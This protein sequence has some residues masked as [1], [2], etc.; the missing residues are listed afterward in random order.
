MQKK[1][2]QYKI[3]H[4]KKLKKGQFMLDTISLIKV[5]TDTNSQIDDVKPVMYE[6]TVMD[7]HH[8]PISGSDI[9]YS[10]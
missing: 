4:D 5:T 8:G 7:S 9:Q 6:K 3:M 2:I 10:L 1:D